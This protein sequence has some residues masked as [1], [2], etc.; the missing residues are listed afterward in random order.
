MTE[1]FLTTILPRRQT[2]DGAAHGHKAVEIVLQALVR[3]LVQTGDDA[4]LS[5]VEGFLLLI[6]NDTEGGYCSAEVR[7]LSPGPP[8]VQPERESELLPFLWLLQ[9]ANNYLL[10]AYLE[11]L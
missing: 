1:R 2:A 11:I 8:C 3:L 10:S 9:K 5:P 6:I 7:L 4:K